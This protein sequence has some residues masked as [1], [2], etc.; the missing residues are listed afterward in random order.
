MVYQES[1][2][3]VGENILP[4]VGIGLRIIAIVHLS[5][6]LHESRDF[7]LSGLLM[8]NLEQSLG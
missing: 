3:G 7:C 6:K 8:I 2:G 4:H 1:L 5:Y